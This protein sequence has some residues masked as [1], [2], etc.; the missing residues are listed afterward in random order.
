MPKRSARDRTLRCA[1]T[2]TDYATRCNGADVRGHL[3]ERQRNS[4]R[5]LTH[6]TK[7]ARL[8]TRG[9]VH[10]RDLR[11]WRG[12][13]LGARCGR[14]RGIRAR[15]SV[16]RGR[17]RA[18]G[19]GRRTAARRATTSSRALR[20]SARA[21]SAFGAHRHA[22]AASCESVG[23]DVCAVKQKSACEHQAIERLKANERAAARMRMLA[24]RRCGKRS[25]RTDEC[26]GPRDDT[27]HTKR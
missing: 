1:R 12:R 13:R 8:P 24:R 17:A 5:T 21:S 16:G 25:P 26:T 9:L 3:N 23:E 27:K 19:R 15:T 7:H 11:R 18:A 14:R 4:M 10:R 2:V 20:S 6:L 22:C